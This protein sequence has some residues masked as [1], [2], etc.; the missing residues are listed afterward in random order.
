MYEIS[1]F[2]VKFIIVRSEIVFL[3]ELSQLSFILAS[4]RRHLCLA[5]VYG[6][7]DS[8]ETSQGLASKDMPLLFLLSIACQEPFSQLF[9][10]AESI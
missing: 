7:Y 4:I 1:R 5:R 3:G 9:L 10:E 6:C 8:K 2:R